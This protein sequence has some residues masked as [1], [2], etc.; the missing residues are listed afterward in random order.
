MKKSFTLIELLIVLVIIGIITAVAI[1]QYNKMAERAVLAE[2][3]Q[4]LDAL[5]T[6]MQMYYTETGKW[7][8]QDTGWDTITRE[9]LI[10]FPP[11][12]YWTFSVKDLQALP[13]IQPPQMIAE[14]YVVGIDVVNF[15]KNKTYCGYS[16]LAIGFNKA[17]PLQDGFRRRYLGF[18]NKDYFDWHDLGDGWNF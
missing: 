13:Q 4:T 12:K 1:P 14:A 8:D 6:A 15:S 7:P 11:T 9:V 5:A 17:N 16:G 2:A 18:R 10:K 3:V